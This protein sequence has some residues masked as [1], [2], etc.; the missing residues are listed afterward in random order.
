VSAAFSAS[1]FWPLA[2]E[3]FL[4]GLGQAGAVLASLVGLSWLSRFLSPS[5]YGCF[6]LATSVANLVGLVF[7][8]PLAAAASRFLEPARERQQHV[9]LLRTLAGL[10]GARVRRLVLPA[11][12]A[13]L[14]CA[15][16][17]S[18]RAALYVI[19]SLAFALGYSLTVL[20]EAIL[21]A[22]RYRGHVAVHRTLQYTLNYGFGLLAAAWIAPTALS[23]LV[24]FVAGAGVTAISEL[25][26]VRRHLVAA[27]VHETDPDREETWRLQVVAYARPYER[28]GGLTWAQQVS[29]RWALAMLASPFDSGLYAMVY[30]LGYTPLGLLSVLVAATIEPVIFARAGDGAEPSRQARAHRLRLLSLAM[31]ASVV[32]VVVV[33]AFAF[34]APLFRVLVDP[35]YQSVSW[36]LPWMALAAGIFGIAQLQAITWLIRVEPTRLE[37]PRIVTAVVGIVLIWSGAAFAGTHGV[38]AAQIAFSIIFF[39]WLWRL[40]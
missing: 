16:F 27:G 32:A 20:L 1:R 30:Q 35:A 29:D 4:V 8:G 3:V 26:V 13:A 15:L 22:S 9:A 25:R 37:R 24:G 10:A 7:F 23:V 31:F 12:I 28:W 38:V 33:A 18:S 14:L 39:M 2:R 40:R 19:G 36:L 17:L 6:V 34:H 21:N 5:E 11:A